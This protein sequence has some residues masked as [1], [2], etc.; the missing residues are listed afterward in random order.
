M[1]TLQ[2]PAPDY[3]DRDFASIN[4]RLELLYIA[5][6][7]QWTD[8][9]R[10]NFGVILKEGMSWVGDVLAYYLDG[11]AREA[12]WGS[13]QQRKSMISHAKLINYVLDGAS[14]ATVEETVTIT[15]T[16]SPG[17]D[18]TIPQGTF[19]STKEVVNPKRF[20]SLTDIIWSSGV[21]GA[22]TVDVENS[23]T[24]QDLYTAT[25]EENEEF[26]LSQI[27]FLDDSQSLT[28]DGHTWT[29]V[30]YFLDS[31]PTDK[32]YKILV[33]ENDRATIRLGDGNNGATASSGGSVQ[34]DYKT[35]GGENGNVEADTITKFEPGSWTDSLGNPVKV[36]VTNVL[37]A[38]GGA[39]RRSNLQSLCARHH[40]AK[41]AAEN[42]ARG[43]A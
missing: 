10:S 16:V 38:D 28:I 30:E 36:E 23:E 4:R 41:T 6:F 8:Y 14:A 43:R 25:G 19:F 12:R 17:G 9:N 21:S 3:T 13:A 5:L 33:D 7:P 42:A 18:V 1:T 37:A 32:H 22:K 27:P 11:Q 20:Q 39:D 24:Q 29:E 2:P 15:R 40:R 31:G 26:I 34:I 35:G